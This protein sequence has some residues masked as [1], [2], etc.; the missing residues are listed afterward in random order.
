MS[1]LRFNKINAFVYIY[2]MNTKHD[3]YNSHE[4]SPSMYNVIR[5][6]LVFGGGKTCSSKSMQDIS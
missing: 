1:N 5:K 6:T 2:D 3:E 4:T